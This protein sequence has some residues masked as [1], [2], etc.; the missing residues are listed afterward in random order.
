MSEEQ[1]ERQRIYNRKR[2]MKMNLLA[3]KAQEMGI[4]VSEKDVQAA[5]NAS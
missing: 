4:E 2:N 3:K 5:L 1:K